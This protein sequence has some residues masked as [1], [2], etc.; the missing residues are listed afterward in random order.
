MYYSA[1]NNVGFRVQGKDT[2]E[3]RTEG[4][5]PAFDSLRYIFTPTCPVTFAT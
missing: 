4:P 3:F 2:L 5:R 1:E